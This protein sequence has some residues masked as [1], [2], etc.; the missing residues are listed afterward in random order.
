MFANTPALADH[1]QQFRDFLNKEYDRY[2]DLYKYSEE[3]GEKRLTFYIS[4]VTAVVGAIVA[5]YSKDNFSALQHYA[6]LNILVIV[7]LAGLIIVGGIIYN[8]LVKR[9]TNTDVYKKNIDNIRD[10]VKL[11]T[12]PANK[13]AEYDFDQNTTSREK[14]KLTSLKDVV[15]VINIFLCLFMLAIYIYSIA[16]DYA[17]SDCSVYSSGLVYKFLLEGIIVVIPMVFTLKSALPSR[18]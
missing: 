3:T 17:D 1:E 2:S 5:L 6:L 11:E 18:K 9:N 7:S 14:K 16:T 12:I 15:L 13:I 8:R 10:L 4:L